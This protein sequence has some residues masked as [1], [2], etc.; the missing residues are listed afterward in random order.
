MTEQKQR[1]RHH[2]HHGQSFLPLSFVGFSFFLYSI[3][4]LF[5][6]LSLITTRVV[7]V[8]EANILLT[9]G[10]DRYYF[11]SQPASFGQ[12]FQDG[13][14]YIARI[15]LPPDTK[16][17]HDPFLCGDPGKPALT[18]DSSTASSSTSSSSNSNEFGYTTPLPPWFSHLKKKNNDKKEAVGQQERIYWGDDDEDMTTP[19]TTTA[20][21]VF[22]NKGRRREEGVKDNRMKLFLNTGGGADDEIVQV[23]NNDKEGESVHFHHR[24]LLHLAHDV[25]DEE[26]FVQEDDHEGENTDNTDSNTDGITI[27]RYSTPVALLVPQGECSFEQKARVA[28]SLSPPDIVQ[29]LIVYDYLEDYNNFTSPVKQEKKNKKSH[30]SFTTSN[31][32]GSGSS[33]DNVL[34]VMNADD[35]RGITLGMLYI[36]RASGESKF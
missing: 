27:P 4:T 12:T 6:F 10:S 14:L 5:L 3:S 30:S 23:H 22:Q 13:Y 7:I 11:S 32:D 9:R 26:F 8:V 15:Q 29:F 28:L 18:Y 16:A 20:G 35:P 25:D 36:S 21:A 24:S 19:T 1:H 2:R 31:D 17:K 33:S 34:K